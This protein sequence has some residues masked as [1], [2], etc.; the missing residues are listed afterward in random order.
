MVRYLNL[1]K[2]MFKKIFR[3]KVILILL[4]IAAIL[5]P[6]IIIFAAL[7]GVSGGYRLDRSSSGTISLSSA[8]FSPYCEIVNNTSGTK[9]YFIPTRY[10]ADWSAFVA[11][12]PA[13]IGLTVCY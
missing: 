9:D 3:P 6:S 2:S 1:V 8:S 4:V 11:N 10:Q 12:H 5:T 13:A 7:T